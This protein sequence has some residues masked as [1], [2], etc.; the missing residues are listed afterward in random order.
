MRRTH[1]RGHGNI[2]KR[3]LIHVGAF[4]RRRRQQ[5]KPLGYSA[6]RSRHRAPTRRTQRMPSKQLRLD[7]HGRPRLSFRRC[8]AGNKSSI[9]FHCWSVS[10]MTTANLI[11]EALKERGA[12]YA[13]RI[14]AN[15]CLMRDIEELL[16]R[17][18][19]RPAH[20]PVV[21]YRGFLYQAASWRTAR[22]V[23]AKV[24]FHAG[25]RG[26]PAI[27]SGAMRFGYGST[28]LPTTLGTAGGGWLCRAESK[29]G[30]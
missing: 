30:R 21:W 11:Y 26:C 20:K 28:F 23:V 4:I 6:G 27:G 17:P 1:L 7:V 9:C 10:I 16:T 19:G 15:D 14:P 2:L 5:V 29:T 25:E 18:V 12:K 3:Q 8:G 22:R 13:I 24:E